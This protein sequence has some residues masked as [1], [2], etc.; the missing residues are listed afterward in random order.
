MDR[1]FV[2]FARNI[3][4]AAQY[5]GGANCQEVADNFGLSKERVRQIL[6]R[7][8]ID[9]RRGGF[10]AVSPEQRER[11][12]AKALERTKFLARHRLLE[13]DANRNDAVV[14]AVRAGATYGE[15]ALAF[16][17]TRGAVAGICDRDKRRQARAA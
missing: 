15:A 11:A 6:I 5:Q 3:A 9:R 2:K 1:V 8:G 14:A 4:I 13:R 12:L 7:M 10:A 17:L 16:G